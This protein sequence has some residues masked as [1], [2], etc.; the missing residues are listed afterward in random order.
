MLCLSLICVRDFT[1]PKVERNTV[2]AGG[3]ILAGQTQSSPLAALLQF[4]FI[5][6]LSD[7]S[8]VPPVASSGTGLALFGFDPGLT[9]LRVV[10]VVANIRQVTVAHI[11][12]GRP[13]QNGPIVL[14]L[15]GPS[16]PKD[17]TAPT[18]LTNATFTAANLTGPLAG[19]PLSVLA[20]QMITGNTYANVHTVAHPDGEIRG[21]IV[22]RF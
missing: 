7:A 3:G 8:E 18:V 1:P 21:P 15:H 12:L 10:L 16:A 9:K 6:S 14:F 13:G 4:Q 17:I 20:Q 2:T 22:R 19:R 5:S 11:H